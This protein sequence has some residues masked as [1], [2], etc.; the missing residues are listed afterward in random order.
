VGRE[1]FGDISYFMLKTKYKRERV[2]M[3]E[4]EGDV[5][6]VEGESNNTVEKAIDT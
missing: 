5:G 4:L 3:I 2:E 1:V 6:E